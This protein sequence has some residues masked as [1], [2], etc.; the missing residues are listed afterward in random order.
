MLHNT[1]RFISIGVGIALVTI[2]GLAKTAIDHVTPL[3]LKLA[4][5]NLLHDRLRFITTIV[6]IVFSMTLVTMQMGLFIS[7]SAW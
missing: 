4:L 1:F 7:F 5:R 6:G 2:W 3:P